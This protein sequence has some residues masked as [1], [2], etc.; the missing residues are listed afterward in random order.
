MAASFSRRCSILILNAE[1]AMRGRATRRLTVGARLDVSVGGRRA[2]RERHRPRHR[3]REPEPDLRSVL[4]D[5]RSRRG[6]GPRPQHLLRH[7][8]RSWRADQRVEQGA[9]RNDVLDSAAGANRAAGRIRRQASWWRTSTRP[10]ATSSRRRS[11]P[12]A[13]PCCA[14]DRADEALA[15]YR[16]G[17]CARRSSI[18]GSSPSTPRNGAGAQVA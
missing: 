7:R 8:P 17:G 10:I 9:G 18:A 1:R 12:G 13:I 11:R 14:T 4:H 3:S 15:R 16:A 6:H 5:P 2:L